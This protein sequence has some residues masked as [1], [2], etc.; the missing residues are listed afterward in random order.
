MFVKSP[1]ITAGAGG[2]VTDYTEGDWVRAIRHGVNPAGHALVMMPSGDYAGM[3]DGDLAALVA[4]ARSLP[5]MRR[6]RRRDPPAAP[7]EGPLR[8]RA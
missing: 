3:S 2:V 1:D 8:R 7:R 6:Q 4:Y 5:P